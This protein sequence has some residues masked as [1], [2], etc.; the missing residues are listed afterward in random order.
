M[1]LTRAKWRMR[2]R[3][4]ST[5]MGRY[6]D[7]SRV[8]VGRFS[9]GRINASFFGA[10]D[11]GLRIGSFCSIAANVHFVCGGNHDVNSFSTFPFRKRFTGR[12]EASSRG[13]IVV[14][15][16]V[17]IGTDALI[18]SGVRLG[19]GAVVAAG[20]VVVKDVPAYAI[21]G[22]VP[23]RVIR[24]RFDE[25]TREALRQVDFDRIDEDFIME[26]IAELSFSLSPELLAVLPKHSA[27]VGNSDSAR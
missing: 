19:Q 13:R 3:H 14:D 1:P 16:D 20:S 18:L 27:G 26:H 25:E 23:A 12:V 5:S 24:Y 9:Y 17:W 2:N 7:V 10:T 11:E 21:V 6:F 4:N 22:G 15:D 8:T